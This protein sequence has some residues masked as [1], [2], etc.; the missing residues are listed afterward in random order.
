MKAVPPEMMNSFMVGAACWR[1][2]CVLHPRR[3]AQSLPNPSI[4]LQYACSALRQKGPFLRAHPGFAAT[5]GVCVDLGPVFSPLFPLVCRA[6]C[7]GRAGRGGERRG[8]TR[9]RRERTRKVEDRERERGASLRREKLGTRCAFRN[10]GKPQ[11]VAVPAMLKGC[12]VERRSLVALSLS[13]SLE[14]CPALTCG[15]RPGRGRGVGNAMDPRAL[16]SCACCSSL[17]EGETGEAEGCS[18]A[19]WDGHFFTSLQPPV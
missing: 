9:E 6:A 5:C 13:L 15:G 4:S 10:Q 17:R 11:H 16:F 7:G 2:C 14:G 19:S 1:R 8:L 12:E 3:I 18:P